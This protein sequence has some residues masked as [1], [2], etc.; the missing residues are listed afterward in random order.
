[1]P[2]LSPIPRKREVLASDP[3]VQPDKPGVEVD[4]DEAKNGVLR[5]TEAIGESVEDEQYREV[6]DVD[7]VTC[8]AESNQRW[9]AKPSQHAQV[10]S[11]A[12]HTNS[13]TVDI[14][15]ILD[16]I[17]ASKNFFV[18]SYTLDQMQFGFMIVTDAAPQSFGA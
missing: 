8:L 16:W 12:E 2:K 14:K 15:A 7:P 17:M 13:G 5:E 1:M 9:P 3:D 6:Q 18:S 11:R 4:R 10:W